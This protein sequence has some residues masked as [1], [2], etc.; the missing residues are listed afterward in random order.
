MAFS[1]S[2]FKTVGDC[3]Y[4]SQTLLNLS[5]VSL[6]SADWYNMMHLLIRI[7]FFQPPRK[8]I[9]NSRRLLHL[10]IQ[11]SCI[12]RIIVTHG[13]VYI[14][15]DRHEIITARPL[16]PPGDLQFADTR[17]LVLG[18]MPHTCLDK[19]VTCS[20][21]TSCQVVSFAGDKGQGSQ[22]AVDKE[23]SPIP[24]PGGVSHFDAC[25]EPINW[26]DKYGSY[27]EKQ[28]SGGSPAF[29]VLSSFQSVNHVLF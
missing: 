19:F 18:N 12:S 17:N 13:S 7:R 10:R 27:K 15:I 14:I 6:P 4:P 29:F 28:V 22:Y 21:H 23:Q 9:V 11:E 8:T 16:E 20:K 2:K 26:F 3:I 24:A 25:H 5:P 1:F